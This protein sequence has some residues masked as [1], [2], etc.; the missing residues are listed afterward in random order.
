MAKGEN[1]VRMASPFQFCPRLRISGILPG[2][3]WLFAFLNTCYQF[4]NCLPRR[5]P[6]TLMFPA[7]T[8]PFFSFHLIFLFSPVLLPSTRGTAFVG[9]FLFH[10]RIHSLKLQLFVFSPFEGL[11]DVFCVAGGKNAE[12]VVG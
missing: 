7:H 8:R 1:Y 12:L 10:F 6:I 11:A 9:Y 2:G 3:T 4:P 5:P